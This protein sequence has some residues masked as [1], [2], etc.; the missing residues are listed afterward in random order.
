MK[1]PAL[2]GIGLLLVGLPLPFDVNSGPALPLTSERPN[3]LLIVID[4]MGYSDVGAFGGEIRT[5][6]VDGLAQSGLRFTQ[7]YV[8]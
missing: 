4:D 5:P 2:V 3:I 7:F 6:H 8:G 1:V